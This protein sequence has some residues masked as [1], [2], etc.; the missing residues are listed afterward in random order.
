[1]VLLQVEKVAPGDSPAANAT[2]ATAKP[3]RAKKVPKPLDV[4]AQPT[5]HLGAVT[6]APVL[7]PRS[8]DKGTAVVTAGEG[9]TAAAVPKARA[10]A[11]T[12][13]VATGSAAVTAAQPV[14][15]VLAGVTAA[16]VRKRT[17]VVTTPRADKESATSARAT[18][19]LA[20]GKNASV[21]EMISLLERRRPTVPTQPAAAPQ[22]NPIIVNELDLDARSEDDNEEDEAKLSEGG[23]DDNE[24]E[25]EEAKL[26]EQSDDEEEEGDVVGEEEEADSVGDV[27][28]DFDETGGAKIASGAHEENV[29]VTAIPKKGAAKPIAS[30]AQRGKGKGKKQKPVASGVSKRVRNATSS[31]AVKAKSFYADPNAKAKP[32]ENMSARRTRARP[33]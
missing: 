16:P 19:V 3:K 10:R 20:R 6:A 31:A 26:S 15:S 12:A 22:Q 28:E 5:V 30:E 4:A 13:P 2:Q 1:M 23:D 27:D 9:V 24:E 14:R 7:S 18:S 8:P 11:T 29:P 33:K 32:Q 25:E 17:E 21:E